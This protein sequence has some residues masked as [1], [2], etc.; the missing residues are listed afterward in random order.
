MSLRLIT[1]SN[2]LVVTLVEAKAQLRVYH[3][4]EDDYISGLVDVAND[5]LCGENSF[6]S[7]S[8]GAGMKWELTLDR[9]PHGHGWP[10]EYFHDGNNGHNRVKLP[11][12]PL[13]SVDAVYYTPSTNVEVQI[14]GFRTL[15]IGVKDGGS[16]L[17]AYNTQWPAT[18]GQPGSVRI[19]FTAGYEKVPASIKHAALLLIAHWYENREAV[20]IDLKGMAPLPVAVDALLYPYRNWF[21]QT[22]T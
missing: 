10:R 18:N 6:I 8:V 12:P 21:V 19:Q 2:D 7:R 16:I 20:T 17:P 11:K 13:V 4:D 15:D 3:T 5:Y 1:P 14:S 9:F 22:A